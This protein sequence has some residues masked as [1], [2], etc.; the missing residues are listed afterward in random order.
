MAVIKVC[1]LV[2]PFPQRKPECSLKHYPSDFLCK[3]YKGPEC[4]N[5]EAKAQRG[6]P[7]LSTPFLSSSLS[8]S[9]L[10]STLHPFKNKKKEK[11]GLNS[12][13]I[14]PWLSEGKPRTAALPGI[15]LQGLSAPLAMVTTPWA[16][17]KPYSSSTST[18]RVPEPLSSWGWTATPRQL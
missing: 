6:S 13:S 2:V 12:T 9:P 3:A 16:S 17:S 1:T 4:T 11:K 15:P 5:G 7:L 14:K 18:G 8:P 10:S